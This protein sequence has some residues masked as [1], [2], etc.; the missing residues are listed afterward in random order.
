MDLVA[1][2]HTKVLRVNFHL[3]LP[4]ALGRPLLYCVGVRPPA[5]SLRPPPRQ[6]C[7]R[8]GLARLWFPAG[9][10]FATRLGFGSGAL[11]GRG[12]A[13]ALV[14]P[15]RSI[16][17][18][19]SGSLTRPA[20]RRSPSDVLS[21]VAAPALARGL[22]SALASACGFGLRLWR[23]FGLR[24]RLGLGV[25]LRRSLGLRLGLGLGVRLGQPWLPAERGFGLGLA[26]RP[27][28]QAW[29]RLGL[30][31]GRSFGLRAW[32]LAFGCGLCF[33]LGCQTW[34]RFWPQVWA[35]SWL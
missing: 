22:G 20:T 12:T 35:R 25:R 13:S 3:L 18:A 8:F 24:L 2:A 11:R 14:T 29:R 28:R 6:P 27:W 17:P 23:C 1:F 16:A 33:R 34:P 7:P 15:R 5:A 21:S 26:A 32:R 19:S 4:A 9:L 10:G 30:G 31:L